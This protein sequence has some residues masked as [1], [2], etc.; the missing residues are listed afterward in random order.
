M[1]IH[2]WVYF[3]LHHLSDA[4]GHSATTYMGWRMA[5]LIMLS[6]EEFFL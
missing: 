3:G 2:I 6:V 1:L 5:S 4:L